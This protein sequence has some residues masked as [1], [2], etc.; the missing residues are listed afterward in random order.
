MTNKY[1]IDI[2]TIMIYITMYIIQLKE[3]FKETFN[4]TNLKKKKYFNDVIILITK[5]MHKTL[6][7]NIKKFF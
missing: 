1:F 7:Q 2:Y 4:I 6:I 5:L 3:L